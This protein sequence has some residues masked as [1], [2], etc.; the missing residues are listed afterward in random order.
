MPRK[1]EASTEIFMVAC[2][3]EWIW[4]MGCYGN[5][6]TGV[7]VGIEWSSLGEW[8]RPFYNYPFLVS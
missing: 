2:S 4:L 6:R 8:G 3:L 5:S 1:M 7:G